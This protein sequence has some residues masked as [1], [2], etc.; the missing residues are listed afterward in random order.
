MEPIKDV[1]I[2]CTPDDRIQAEELAAFL[3]TSGLTCAVSPGDPS[4][5]RVM[6][7]FF[8]DS[9]IDAPEIL[10]DVTAAAESGRTIIPYRLTAADP[11]GSLG[12]FLKPLH[13][14]NAYSMPAADAKAALADLCKAAIRP[15]TVRA[16]DSGPEMALLRKK[17]QRRNRILLLAVALVAVV[18]VALVG[19]AY[20]GWGRGVGVWS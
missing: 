6:V 12:F 4:L 13:W 7:L 9:V 15:Q 1:Y 16:D 8:T 3:E 20:W 18:A 17:A 19:C 5:A 10:K 11:S 2:S 14:L